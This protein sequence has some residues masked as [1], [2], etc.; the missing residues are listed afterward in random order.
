MKYKLITASVAALVATVVWAE[1]AAVNGNSRNFSTLFGAAGIAG[2]Y[3]SCAITSPG[4]V[5]TVT[6]PTAGQNC[7]I[8]PD[9]QTISIYKL[10]LC[11]SKPG[12]PTTAAVSSSSTCQ[13]LYTSTSATGS[14]VSIVLNATVALP[15]AD[16]VKPANNTYTHLYVEIDPEVKIKSSLKFSTA[17]QFWNEY[18]GFDASSNRL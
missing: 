2:A 13:F 14:P 15:A 7:N 18:V 17:I 1:G 11:T 9:A 5:T 10:A 4:G 12:A 3:P 8:Q 6:P 16:I